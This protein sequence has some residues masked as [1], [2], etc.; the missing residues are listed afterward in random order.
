[1]AHTAAGDI[2]LTG[3]VVDQA[4]II[5]PADEQRLT[6]QLARLE[7]ETTDQVVI[8]T[9]P[10]LNGEAIEKVGLALGNGWG[11]GQADTDNGVLLL[12]AP[13][14]RKVRIEVGLGLEGLLTD[15][16]AAKI[17]EMMLP[18]FRAGK[19]AEAIERGVGEISIL[20]RSDLHRP[21]RVQ[22]KIAA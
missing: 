2:A 8:V 21:Q 4:G 11:I 14:D 1:V 9:L 22:R 17:I 18:S 12:V 3:R 6:Q 19:P 10:S 5:L 13:H 15:A 16:R 7:R 20:L